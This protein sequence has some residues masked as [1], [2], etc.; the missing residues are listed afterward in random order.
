MGLGIPFIRF[1]YISQ[2]NPNLIPNFHYISVDRPEELLID[3]LGNE[4]HAKMIERKFLEVKDNK[5]FLEYI[6]TN[7]RKYYETY[8]TQISRVDHTLNLLGL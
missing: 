6:S 3:R 1:N 4:T 5:D 8:L 7:S 2:L